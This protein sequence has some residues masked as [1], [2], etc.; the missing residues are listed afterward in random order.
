MKLLILDGNSVINRAYFGVKPL[1]TREGLYTHAIYGFLNI[2]ERMEKEE[3]PEAICVAFD[4]HGPTFRHLKYD[5]YKANRHGMPEELAQQMP[6]MKDVLRAMNI[7]IYECQGW[8]AD[9][10]IGTVGKICS[11][12]DWECVIV[13]GDRDSLQLIDP[14]VHVKLVISKPGQT[15]ATLYTEEKFREEYGFEPKKLI[16]LKALMGDS[17]DNIPGVAGVGPKT[18]K[19]LLAKFGSL[20]GVY[21][22]IDD[23]SIRPKLREKL[24]NDKENAY[25]SYDLATI[26]PE[27]PIDFEPRD[28]IVQPYNR[29]EL[30]NLF[31]KLEFVRLI[32]KYG[33]RG[34]AAEAPKPE[35]KMESLPR[36]DSLPE[37]VTCCAVY[38]AGD[39]SIGIAC[40][41][42]VCALT[43]MEAQMGGVVLSD[44]E[45]IFHDS[46]TTMHRLDEMDISFGKCL[47]DT[48]LAAYDL[49][50]SQSD[51]PISKLA[52]NFLG[53]GV[54]DEDAAACAEAL[55][56][57]RPVLTEE[58]KKNG[59]EKLYGEIEL[60]L[61][62]VLYRMEKRGIAIDRAQLEQFG[63]MLSQRIADCEEIIFSYADGR[64]NINSTKQLG[65]LLF[66]KLGLPPVKKTKTGY[67]T[68]AD[69]LE[70][71]KDKHPII[72]AIMDY[73]ML[74]KLKS[75]YADGLIKEIREDGRIHTTF[76][77]LVT[78]TG[79]LSSTEPNLQ[80][81][82]VRTDLGAE[83]RKM[84]VP[85]PGCV[86]VDADYSQIEL[87]VLAHIAEDKNMQ[88]AFCSGADIH[89]ATAAQVFNVPVESVTPLQ[90]RHAKAVNFGIVY[91]ISEFSLAEDIGVSR[92]EARDYIDNYLANYRGVRTYMKKV[93]EDAKAIGY[94]Q[95][96]YGRKRYIPE[97]KSSNFNIRSGAERI[98]LNTPIQGTAADIIKLAMIR[99]EAALNESFPEAELLLQVHDELIVECPAE[100][101]EQ[102]AQL[103]SREMQN[104]AQLNVPLTAEAKFGK[105]WYEAK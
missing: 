34:A 59:M 5:G 55:W 81:I 72:P 38:L 14:N 22:N 26:R 29:P 102:V 3:Q 68:N 99:V 98:A 35:S 65:E 50:P 92:Y 89:T 36:I 17:S 80:N 18:A 83:I 77:N 42:C 11:N 97:L 39:G 78:A 86:L 12:N 41:K 52:T 54:E 9:D 30:Y 95:T 62:S 79:R 63:T 10:V 58:L 94:T 82:P 25:L 75:T 56:N 8:E 40:E 69:V 84:F 44:K 74:T 1:T 96:L 51:Y 28:A 66:E 15:N 105:S 33:L 6:I 7:P 31:Q 60:P 48:A 21:E 45:I 23:S 57:L 90:R 73:R 47:F 43:P 20:D 103:V 85:K 100:I 2:L 91:G 4:L 32:D 67:S 46:K 70:K 49:N 27:A 24:L 93:V 16:D 64:F 61:C 53:A 104:V 71:L 88:E 13:T 37:E 87:R 76:Q 101:A 19:E